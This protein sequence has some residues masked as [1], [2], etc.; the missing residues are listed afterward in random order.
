M[1]SSKGLVGLAI[2][3]ALSVT[4]R[5][6]GMVTSFTETEKQMVSVERAVQYIEDVQ[7]EISPRGTVSINNKWLVFTSSNLF[8]P[9][10]W[11]RQEMTRV[12]TLLIVLRSCGFSRF[13]HNCFRY[14]IFFGTTI[15]RGSCTWREQSNVL[16]FLCASKAFN[17]LL[18]LY[19][20]RRILYS[21]LL[22]IYR[23]L[24]RLVH[25][26]LNSQINPWVMKLTART[27]CTDFTRLSIL[28]LNF[29]FRSFP[30]GHLVV[31]L[32]S[33]KSALFIGKGIRNRRIIN[34]LKLLWLIL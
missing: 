33:K 4:D 10:P 32:P 26:W 23:H 21:W 16:W 30:L 15:R 20:L 19:D 6:S 1:P 25:D 28:K 7:P 27:T 14:L 2:S 18:Y 11:L 22:S 17:E 9:W 29:T 24:R 13:A 5:L 8:L 34:S 3:Y 31:S 12:K